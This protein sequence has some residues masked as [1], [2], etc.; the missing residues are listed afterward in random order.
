MLEGLLL[1]LIL[2]LIC[3]GDGLFKDM[4]CSVDQL[5]ILDDS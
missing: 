1:I 4:F 5:R 3:D 2:I